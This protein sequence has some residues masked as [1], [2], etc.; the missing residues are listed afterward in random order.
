MRQSNRLLAMIL[1]IAMIVSAATA[2]FVVT[3]SAAEGDNLFSGLTMSYYLK[4]KWG[5]YP[6]TSALA[7]D[8][9]FR[10]DGTNA[11]N[12]NS[13]VSG[14]TLDT[15][16]LN[17]A[18]T[19]ENYFVFNLTEAS[20]LGSICINGYRENGN[21]NIGT[22]DLYVGTADITVD[23]TNYETVASGLTKVEFTADKA[24]I[25]D[26]P[27]A[28]G[29]D[30]Y[31][32]LTLSFDA[33]SN[34]KSVLLVTNVGR[35]G[36]NFFQFDEIE[37]YAPAAAD[38]PSSS[39]EETSEESSE[40][41]PVQGS[42]E[43]PYDVYEPMDIV[44]P[45]NSTVYF[46]VNF[47]GGQQMVVTADGVEVIN[48]IVMGFYAPYSYENNTDADVTL[49][50]NFVLPL[51]SMENPAEL[52]I[53]E[54]TADIAA[55]SQGYFY[56]WTATEAGT[57]SITMPAGQWTYTINN[58]TSS[59][60]GDAQWSDSDPVVPVGTVDVAAGD[61]IQIIV[62]TYDSADPWN[63]PAG[64]FTFTAA[65]EA[66]EAPV[67]ESDNILLG[68]P[69]TVTTDATANKADGGDYVTDG[70]FRGDGTNAFNGDS[71]VDGVSIEWFGTSK[72]ITYTFAFDEATD[73]AEIVF[74]SVRIASNRAFGTVVVN[75]ST[76]VMSGD[77][78]K[79]A[80]AGAPGY[81]DTNAD[82]YFD[83]SIPVELTGITELTIAL[84]TDMY[85]CQYDE[86]EAYATAREDESSDV[87]VET[88]EET[89]E[90]TSDVSVETSD[91]TSDETS[92]D[93]SESVDESYLE[94]EDNL[95]LGKDY[96]VVT[97]A[98]VS[99]ADSGNLMTNGA[100]RG[101]KNNAWNGDLGVNDVSVEWFGTSKTI[102][103]TFT[104]DAA[105]DVSEI[106]F[107]NVR[108]AS[109]RAFGTLVI[110]G[111]TIV[112]SGQWTKTPVAGA[113]LYGQDGDAVEQYFDVS[114]AVDLQGITELSIGLITDMYVCQYDEIMA[115]GAAGDEP[116][117]DVE[118]SEET[119]EETSE[120]ISSEDSEE[121]SEVI[122]SEESEE[123][124]ETSFDI[125][126]EESEETS[127][128]TSDDETSDDVADVVYGDV[129]N[130][131][132]VN[133]L[134]AAQTLKHDAKLITLDDA[135]LAAADVNGDGT[136]NSLDAAQV[137]KFD[138][139]LIDSFPVEDAADEE[140]SEELSAIESSD[141]AIS[142][143][144]EDSS[145]ESSDEI[146]A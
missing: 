16:S 118:P 19:T 109:N 133:S 88:S 12:G 39:E 97:D 104:F 134:D 80:I 57:L 23:A 114:V 123:S 29:E 55:G 95:L 76:I 102:T 35:T 113:P 103:Y 44:A 28:N 115:F 3:G 73:I 10:G 15:A 65:F 4:S 82:Q 63:A 101:D 75:G 48:E 92:E 108:I 132:A 78:V 46:N 107:R 130:D 142:E 7:T 70:N 33:I 128:E 106:V 79:T 112:M 136:V 40:D 86:I 30:Q 127:E 81:G 71:A 120:V 62:C 14:V 27:Q 94:V 13:A 37:A 124:E 68:K 20:D 6:G 53:G 72:T 140:S 116:S 96:T 119:S 26:A 34:V 87:S 5:E 32:N 117:S 141:A 50:I 21:R 146:S 125:T 110:N 43:F 60:Y 138:A 89:S 2:M 47:K 42:A 69:Y 41:E 143:D 49:S 61:K 54:N 131:G 8:G 91:E 66:A 145:V 17:S 64:L 100:I 105:T 90:E 93:S 83:V 129:N 122:T 24:L 139:K 36:S 99:K 59:A 74:K 84:I 18:G 135:A 31:F 85:V 126:S 67:V 58:L 77:A 52:V 11:W 38:E 56:T 9:N 51:G 1:V 22:Y 45:A 137:L 111:S 144:E 25:A 121:T 98:T